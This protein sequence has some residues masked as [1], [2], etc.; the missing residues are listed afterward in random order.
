MSHTSFFFT[1]FALQEW[2]QER[3]NCDLV[4]SPSYCFLSSALFTETRDKPEQGTFFPRSLWGGEM[5]D[6]GNEVGGDEAPT[7]GLLA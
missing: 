5:T 3:Q 1:N 4:M 6:S 2:F 7:H